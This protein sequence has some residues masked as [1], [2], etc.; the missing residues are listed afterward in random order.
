MNIDKW[1]IGAYIYYC[2]DSISVEVKKE[3]LK[4]D[5]IDPKERMLKSPLENFK[6]LQ[7]NN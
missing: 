3:E 7:K 2:G 6:W 4:E 5:N 1:V